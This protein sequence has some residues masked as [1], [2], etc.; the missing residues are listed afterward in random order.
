MMIDKTPEGG[1][2]PNEADA[3]MMRYAPR[4]ARG[5]YKLDAWAS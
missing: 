5:R 4:K 3:V 1:K 2:S